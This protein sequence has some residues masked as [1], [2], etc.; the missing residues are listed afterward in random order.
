MC[1]CTKYAKRKLTP[2]RKSCVR[3]D[4]VHE[5]MVQ[6]MLQQIKD[7][8]DNSAFLTVFPFIFFG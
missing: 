6:I 1:L 7:I 5:L 2:T 8:Y 3:E 4:A